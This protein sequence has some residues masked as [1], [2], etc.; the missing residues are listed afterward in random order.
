MPAPPALPLPAAR[1]RRATRGTSFRP[2]DPASIQIALGDPESL[3]G[4]LTSLAQEA[5]LPRIE[6]LVCAIEGWVDHVMDSVG[7]RLIGSYPSLSE[8]LKRR[9][10]E[11]GEGDRF[12]ERMLG[13][14]LGQQQY[15]RGAAFVR[16][17]VERAGEP[18]LGRLWQSE[19][20]L[21]TPAEVDAP[22]LWLERIDLPD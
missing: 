12:V 2:T 22:G 9:R 1:R 15:D 4:A 14:E 17:I 20:E 16:G 21:P 11:R 18:A 10:V 8:A 13:L 5:L 3:L 6:A 7:R 19:R